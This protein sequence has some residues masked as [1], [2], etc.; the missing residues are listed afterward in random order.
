MDFSQVIGYG[1]SDLFLVICV[2]IFTKRRYS[3]WSTVVVLAGI[4]L[5]IVF[6]VYLRVWL[7]Y[8]GYVQRYTMLIEAAGG[9]LVMYIMAE[10]RDSRSLFSVLLAGAYGMFGHMIWKIFMAME[11]SLPVALAV[12]IVIQSA[13]LFV[14]VRFLLPSYRRLQDVYRSEWKDFCLVI[15]MTYACM[16]LLFACLKRPGVTVFHN[17]VA[18]VYLMT[19]YLLLI[20]AFRLF[21]RILQEEQEIHNRHILN[22]SMAVLKREIG[23]IHR[24]EKQI[25]AY[26]HDNRHFIRM[27]GGMMAEEDYEGVDRALK[28]MQCMPVMPNTIKYCDNMPLN[29]VL[30]YYARIARERRIPINVEMELPEKIGGYEWELAVVLG[31]LLDSAIQSCVEV[32][33][34]TARSIFVKGRRD[35][36]QCMMEIRNTFSGSILFDDI[37]HLPVTKKGEVHGLGM[38]SVADFVSEHNGVLD[39][40]IENNWYYVKILL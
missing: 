14:L 15:V 16:Y 8:H 1:I 21:D 24:V 20:M 13:F 11:V 35:N 37:T 28:Q 9:I 27:I 26:N 3:K 4:Y 10:Y 6:L 38:H 17:A 31:N 39:C 19:V 12:E 30:S 34:Y 36:G 22:A 5:W 2:Y 7:Q 32:E 40:G 18:L 29:G 23:E 33:P 25:A